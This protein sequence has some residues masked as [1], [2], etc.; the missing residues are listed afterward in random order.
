MRRSVALFGF[1]VAAVAAAEEAEV[2]A[3]LEEAASAAAALER[4]LA[5][6]RPVGEP[7]CPAGDCRSEEMNPSRTVQEP[8][9]DPVADDV[10]PSGDGSAVG[11]G[12]VGKMHRRGPGNMG[13][14]TP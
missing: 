13:A 12:G 3:R 14:P 1:F 2:E 7:R 4:V 5:E 10:A 8:D 6:S 11:M 9:G